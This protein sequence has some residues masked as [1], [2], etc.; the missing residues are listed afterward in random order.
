MS[1]FREDV[2]VRVYADTTPLR[3]QLEKAD[4]VVEA[5]AG[6]LEKRLGS[7]ARIVREL[8]AAARRL[9]SGTKPAAEGM[10]QLTD[11]TTAAGQ[12]LRRIADHSATA[13][14]G[15][16][17]I[18]QAAGS[19]SD[20]V[21][22]LSDGVEAAGTALA[23]AANVAGDF[24]GQTA[25]L[26]G[27]VASANNAFTAMELTV[28]GATEGVLGV[29]KE[30]RETAAEAVAFSDQGEEAKKAWSWAKRGAGALGIGLGLNEMLDRAERYKKAQ[31][32]IASA[33]GDAADSVERDLFRIAQASDQ[34]FTSLAKLTDAF[35]DLGNAQAA[36]D[37]M[38]A[39]AVGMSAIPDA[40]GDT[41]AALQAYAEALKGGS[42][43]LEDFDSMARKAPGAVQVMGK[44]LGASADEMRAMA[45]AGELTAGRLHSA[46][47]ETL[48]SIR[49]EA[50]QT[51]DTLTDH[52]QKMENSLTRFAGRVSAIAGSSQ[53][54][55]QE[56][57]EV[58]TWL[59]SFETQNAAVEALRMLVEVGGVA[60]DVLARLVENADILLTVFA[61]WKMGKALTG[62]GFFVSSTRQAN[63]ALR[64]VSQTINSNAGTWTRQL[65]NFGVSATTATRS[66]RGLQTATSGLVRGPLAALGSA[67][68]A[69]NPLSMVATAATGAAAAY[70][71]YASRLSDAQEAARAHRKAEEALRG[72]IASQVQSVEELQAK[73]AGLSDEK[74]RLEKA[75]LVSALQSEQEALRE[76]TQALENNLAGVRRLMFEAAESG[77]FGMSAYP[78]AVRRMEKVVESL[79]GG[80]ISAGEAL[81][82]LDEIAQ[83][84][85]GDVAER[86]KTDLQGITEPLNKLAKRREAIEQTRAKLAVLKGTATEAQRDLLDLGDAT[87]KAGDAAGDAAPKFEELNSTLGD[88]LDAM[89]GHYDAAAGRLE[90]SLQRTM[91]ALAVDPDESGLGS[92]LRAQEQKAAAVREFSDEARAAIDRYYGRAIDMA[93]Q[94]GRD[95]IDLEKEALSARKD[96]WAEAEDRYK[97][98]YERFNEAADK[99]LEKLEEVRDRVGDLME[100]GRQAL[101]DIELAGMDP[102]EKYRELQETAEEKARS[103]RQ[104]MERGANERALSLAEEAQQAAQTALDA[105]PEQTGGEQGGRGVSMRAGIEGP[106]AEEARRAAADT[107]RTAMDIGQQAGDAMA[108]AERQAAERMRARAED[109]KGRLDTVRGKIRDINS[110]LDRLGDRR[111]AI[112][113]RAAQKGL[114][115]VLD[116]FRELDRYM[117][118]ARIPPFQDALSDD[119]LRRLTDIRQPGPDVATLPEDNRLRLPRPH[120]MTQSGSMDVDDTPMRAVEE[121]LGRMAQGVRIPLTV[122]LAVQGANEAGG[123]AADHPSVQGALMEWA[124]DYLESHA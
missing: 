22:I 42:A 73:Y 36:V 8:T 47:T 24:A 93:E 84:A 100:S 89:V 63:T 40:A 19:A 97:T 21:E 49:K 119:R 110:H 17:Q 78:D 64:A 92:F 108:D 81:Q 101:R 68:F 121:R 55:G 37:Q 95:T 33:T 26:V 56:L 74:E 122:D 80:A 115:K 43:S 87:Q 25:E 70:A 96:V 45:E 114:D 10:R 18:A 35:A 67:T 83:D 65:Q 50:G 124:R 118:K 12:G 41:Q 120:E 99:H 109:V 29:R 53:A 88:S 52:A 71:V 91:Q 107:I 90:S 98:M 31:Q 103:A 123:A 30:L 16:R 85:G 111:L 15:V 116:R 60:G 62:M 6:Q 9:P 94:A 66:V 76:Q 38:E 72:T 104:A 48:P 20:N 82:R 3:E 106:S 69:I 117:G 51:A 27:E 13:G 77:Q 75:N 14:Q 2:A 112:D 5:A 7:G 11:Q 39:I 86:Y 58:R 54:I 1:E 28:S 32:A 59:N 113:T 105:R 34:S 46:F 57:G 61:T 102:V 4:E 79:R 44:A 23:G